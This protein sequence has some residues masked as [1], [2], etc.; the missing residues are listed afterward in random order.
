MIRRHVAL[1]LVGGVLACT[2]RP[3]DGEAAP[4]DQPVRDRQPVVLLKKLIPR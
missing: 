1:A 2:D 4:R 3:A